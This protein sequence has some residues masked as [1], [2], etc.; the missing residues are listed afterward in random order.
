MFNAKP[1][2]SSHS[3]VNI[4]AIEPPPNFFPSKQECLKLI[5]V[6]AIAST[7]AWTCNLFFN[8]VINPQTKPFCDTNLEFLDQFS[9]EA[10]FFLK[11]TYFY[12]NEGEYFR[13]I[14]S[15][16]LKP[17][18]GFILFILVLIGFPKKKK[19]LSSL[20]LPLYLRD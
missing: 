9:G 7:I 19:R 12:E 18:H 2:A 3:L 20:Y 15:L 10:L 16:V 11:K 5:V 4:S 6:L 13:C 8:S 14:A 17:T 1:S